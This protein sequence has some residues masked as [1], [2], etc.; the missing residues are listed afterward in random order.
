MH[1]DYLYTDEFLKA[2]N[3]LD[4]SDMVYVSCRINNGTVFK[5][6]PE[7]KMGYC[8]GF[9]KFIRRKF[10]GNYRTREDVWN[11]DWYLNNFLQSLPH[12]EKFTNLVP[13]HYNFPREGSMYWEATH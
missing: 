1:D 7:S 10:L 12:T 2:L 3:E 6:T 11:E 8:A 9:T 4:G 13:Y 5:V